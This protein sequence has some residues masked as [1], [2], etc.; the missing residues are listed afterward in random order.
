MVLIDGR[1]ENVRRR[2]VD[3][4]ETVP[5][6]R[7]PGS[8]AEIVISVRYDVF[9]ARESTRLLD[10]AGRTGFR[11]KYIVPS[12]T[13]VVEFDSAVATVIRPY[14]VHETG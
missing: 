7:T 6:A 14:R 13:I 8:A 5:S 12:T 11:A 4:P 9:A 2:N 10:G 3:S 1:R